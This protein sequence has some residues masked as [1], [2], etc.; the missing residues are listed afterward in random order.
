MALPY[1]YP[2]GLHA[3]PA[4]IA[5]MDIARAVNDAM[6]AHG[7]MPISTDIGDCLFTALDIA[8]TALV[9]PGYYA[10]MAMAWPPAWV[11]RPVAARAWSS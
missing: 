6:G 5:P 9:A 11:F 3:D 8:D 2:Y 1:R 7:R 10:T 4:P